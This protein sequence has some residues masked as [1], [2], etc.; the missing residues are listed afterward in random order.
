MRSALPLTLVLTRFTETGGLS[1]EDRSDPETRSVAT[2]TALRNR[3]TNRPAADPS[4]IRRYRVVWV[5][6]AVIV[7]AVSI[8]HL[9]PSGPANGPGQSAPA[10]KITQPETESGAR[11]PAPPAAPAA[12]DDAVAAAPAPLPPAA[13]SAPD[14][15]PKPAVHAAETNPAPTA[16]QPSPAALAPSAGAPEPPAQA[17]AE[18]IIPKASSGMK[19]VELVVCR[20]VSKHQS[21]GPQTFFRYGR[22]EKPHV[23]MTVYARHPPRKLTH[24]YFQDGREHCKVPLTIRHPRTRTW[25]RLTID[26]A[27]FAGSWRVAVVTESGEVLGEAFFEVGP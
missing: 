5:C 23:W 1:P 26:S 25:S 8:Y 27:K 24:V 12:R 18:K 16:P 21:T 22:S 14:V 4:G 3:L 17:S 2:V 11:P 9:L 6:A 7:A 10:A 19:L 13:A 20:R 15:Q